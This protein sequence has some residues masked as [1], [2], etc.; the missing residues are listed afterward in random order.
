MTD[1]ADNASRLKPED[2]S[3]IASA[4]DVPV[5]IFGI[6]PSID[7]PSAESSTHSVESI[8]FAGPLIDDEL[9]GVAFVLVQEFVNSTGGTWPNAPAQPGLASDECDD[10]RHHY[11]EPDDDTD[12]RTGHSNILEATRQSTGLPSVHDAEFDIRLR[13][14]ADDVSIGLNQRHAPIRVSRRSAN[15]LKLDV[16]LEVRAL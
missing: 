9:D 8:A 5:Y 12:Q 16:Y 6:V 14:L 15:G 4:I 11:H 13:D 3:A 2:V 1:G 10:D 7:N